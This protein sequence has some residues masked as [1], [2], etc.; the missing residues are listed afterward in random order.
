MHNDQDEEFKL[1]NTHFD[2]IKLLEGALQ[3]M[4]GIISQGNSV[5]E[6]PNVLHEYLIT[7]LEYLRLV[8]VNN[9]ILSCR[10]VYTVKLSPDDCN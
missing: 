1:S 10:L 5:S 2:A 9:D 7:F 4:D 8:V 6:R 3:K